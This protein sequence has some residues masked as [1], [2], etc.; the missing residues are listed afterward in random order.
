MAS[1]CRTLEYLARSQNVKVA[2]CE[3]GTL[4]V[5]YSHA[6]F[7]FNEDGVREL[8]QALGESLS[9]LALQKMQEAPSLRL[10][11]ETPESA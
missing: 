2:Q 5:A 3:C 1:R 10:I 11:S 9:K 7:H 4:H 8:Y 6:T